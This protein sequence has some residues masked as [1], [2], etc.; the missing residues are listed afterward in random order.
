MSLLFT[1]YLFISQITLIIKHTN[2]NYLRLTDNDLKQL[3]KVFLDLKFQ[4]IE[5][6][7]DRVIHVNESFK[8]EESP[9][10]EVY[11]NDEIYASNRL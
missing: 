6:T 10:H 2:Y 9:I 1:Y 8:D 3:I 5:N 4:M 11:G 7:G